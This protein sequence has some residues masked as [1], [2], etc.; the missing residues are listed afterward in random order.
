VARF[1][2]FDVQTHA[3]VLAH[4]W[5]I[6]GRGDLRWARVQSL[7][8]NGDRPWTVPWSA[9]AWMR[10][11]IRPGAEVAESSSAS[12]GSSDE[13]WPCSG[14]GR[15]SSLRSAARTIRYAG[16]AAGVPDGQRD[17]DHGLA[18]EHG[19]DGRV[20]PGSRDDGGEQ[21]DGAGEQF[22]VQVQV[23]RFLRAVRGVPVMPPAV[24]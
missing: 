20:T 1:D 3:H 4:H 8:R 2:G 18:N 22:G 19:G 7:T 15:H 6:A 10:V 16:R 17:E 24:T 11:D 23:H 5:G 12:G 14:W 21:P 9:D 13:V